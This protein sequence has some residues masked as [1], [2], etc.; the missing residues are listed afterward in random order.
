M[1]RNEALQK[2]ISNWEPNQ[3]ADLDI[4]M[5]D[6]DDELEGWFVEHCND[7]ADSPLHS[8]ADQNDPE[9]WAEFIVET[10][11]ECK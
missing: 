10:Y 8:E 5:Q 4:W 3:V 6:C 7:H 2:Q 11:Y 9:I 1:T